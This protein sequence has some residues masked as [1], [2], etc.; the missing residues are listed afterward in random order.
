MFR[1]NVPNVSG[2]PLT[3]PRNSK[4]IPPQPLDP[5]NSSGIPVPLATPA[6]FRYQVRNFSGVPLQRS[7]RQRRPAPPS[8]SS[9]IPLPG[10]QL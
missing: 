5:S 1:Y 10:P 3:P 4:G 6:A 7:Q 8:N 9:G 2:I